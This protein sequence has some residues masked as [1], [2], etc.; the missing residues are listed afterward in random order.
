MTRKRLW[1]TASVVLGAGALRRAL[2]ATV[3]A[4]LL[5]LAA[6]PARA[7]EEPLTYP[8]PV[9][10][11]GLAVDDGT[12]LHPGQSILVEWGGQWWTG[13]VLW[14]DGPQVRIHYRGWESS[15]D[16]VVPR[17]RLQHIAP[18]G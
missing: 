14:A 15:W 8:G 13:A 7:G 12:V 17:T 1:T 5:A 18:E 9:A 4:T 11:T 16:E 2:I 10:A 6:G 3:V